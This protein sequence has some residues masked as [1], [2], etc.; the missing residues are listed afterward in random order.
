[1]RPQLLA[2]LAAVCLSTTTR[3]A[4]LPTFHAFEQLRFPTLDIGDGTPVPVTGYLFRPP[5]DT[6]RA[7][8][9]LMHGCGAW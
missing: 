2:L 1:M 7:A 4:N 3:A 9:V 8:V 5:T 6:P